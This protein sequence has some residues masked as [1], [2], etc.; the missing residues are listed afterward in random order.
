MPTPLQS[1]YAAI[2]SSDVAAARRIVASHP[3]LLEE[4]L[5]DG[6]TLLH[7]AATIDNVEMVRFFV[8]CGFDVDAHRRD[9]ADTPLTNAAKWNAINVA[10]WLLEHGAHVD[11]G[12]NEGKRATPLISASIEGH[13]GMVKLLVEYGAD[14]DL[15]Y[16]RDARTAI[17]SAL[18]FGHEDIAEFLRFRC[19][20]TGD[21]EAVPG[22]F[23][24]VTAHVEKHLGP[25]DTAA[26]TEIVG[27][28][29][30]LVVQQADQTI[31]VTNGMSRTAMTVPR[32]SEAYRHA[33]LLIRLPAD[34]PAPMQ[35]L[36]DSWPVQWLRNI[37]HY[38]HANDT[39]L[40]G[41]SAII[42]N[43]EPPEPLGP[44]TQFTCM[45]LLAEDSEFGCMKAGDGRLI[46]FYSLFPLYT[47]ERDLE[48]REGIVVLVE[49]F[50]RLGISLTIDLHRP[51]VA[52]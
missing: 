19:D 39:W 30:I 48:Q 25:V 20:R 42:A 9:D 17:K 41:S 36:R 6:E 40:G 33:E 13:L 37:A 2:Q 46:T 24:E 22:G 52:T 45:L 38:P 8:D 5:P 26:L 12:A 49:R 50:Q 18:M 1:I 16:G 21:H 34:W 11:G 43:G 31:L 47:E 29:R 28:L 10:R 35:T 32:G 44:G 27:D 3:E 23:D 14:L 51:N 7:E 4:Y 15:A